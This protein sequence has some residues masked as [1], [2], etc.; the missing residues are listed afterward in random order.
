MANGGDVARDTGQEHES[1]GDLH[2]GG[3]GA[4][5]GVFV[6]LLL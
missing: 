6:C 2:V 4:K 3:F 5:L 1:T